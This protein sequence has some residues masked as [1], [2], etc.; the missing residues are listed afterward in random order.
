MTTGGS[1]KPYWKALGG[2]AAAFVGSV[3]VAQADGI[4]GGEW[5]TIVGSTV[6][7]AILVFFAPYQSTVKPP[8]ST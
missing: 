5:A 7:G 1:M 4:T 3:G 6:A 8:P 2:A